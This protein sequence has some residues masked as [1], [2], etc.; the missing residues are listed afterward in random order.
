MTLSISVR[1][2]LGAMA[3]E[4]YSALPEASALVKP[5]YQI[6]K[7]HNRTFVGGGLPN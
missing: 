2:D 7:G 5:H 1:V 6:V 4:G 3:I